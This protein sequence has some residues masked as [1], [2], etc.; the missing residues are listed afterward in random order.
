M[1]A[2]ASERT[3][4]K[5]TDR[6]VL[7]RSKSE[8]SGFMSM[9]MNSN[10]ERSGMRRNGGS[11]RPPARSMS[12]EAGVTWSPSATEAPPRISP[13]VNSLVESLLSR[14]RA[15]NSLDALI[16]MRLS[17]TEHSDVR[18]EFQPTSICLNLLR[19]M[20]DNMEN[21]IDIQLK[22]LR[23]IVDLTYNDEG[24]FKDAF[25][26]TGAPETIIKAMRQFSR[27]EEMQ[28]YGCGALGNLAKHELG[29][30]ARLVVEAGAVEVILDAMRTHPESNYVQRDVCRFL[31]TIASKDPKSI[32][33]I[34]DHGG[35]DLILA[36][37]ENH[38]HAE[39]VQKSGVKLLESLICHQEALDQMR[40][41]GRLTL[42]KVELQF[43]GKND[44]IAKQVLRLLKRLNRAS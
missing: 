2:G 6:R 5:A 15:E 23:L 24:H 44:E 21:S 39:D 35:V 29:T 16:D 1:F 38:P 31:R 13:V 8:D 18:K 30:T 20:Q 41:K 36:A 4:K 22:S 25:I 27:N 7:A 42:S 11:R 3:L 14:E 40:Q 34:S 10:S 17:R 37:L 9:A 32:A 28:T 19:C 26:S 43:Q 33:F 12:H